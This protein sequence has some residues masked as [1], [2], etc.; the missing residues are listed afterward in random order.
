MRLWQNVKVQTIIVDIWTNLTMHVNYLQA[1]LIVD[2][3]VNIE[4]VRYFISKYLP[5]NQYLS[6]LV[7]MVLCL[8][9]VKISR[10]TCTIIVGTKVQNIFDQKWNFF[11]TYCF[12]YF[13]LCW[14]LDW[15]ALEKKCKQFH[16]Y[17]YQFLYLLTLIIINYNSFLGFTVSFL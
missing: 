6:L 13:Y 11:A 1:S 14:L 3:R 8:L 4:C 12:I 17:I 7:Y 2:V 5:L 16:A 10:S 15:Q 9:L